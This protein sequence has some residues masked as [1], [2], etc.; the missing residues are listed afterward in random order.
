MQNFKKIWRAWPSDPTLERAHLPQT[1]PLGSSARS[2]PL[3]LPPQKFG[4]TPLVACDLLE[5][6]PLKQYVCGV[7]SNSITN[8]LKVNV[9]LGRPTKQQQLAT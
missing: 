1:A 3:A 8:C 5:K 7:K 6:Q 4:L 2:A 9:S